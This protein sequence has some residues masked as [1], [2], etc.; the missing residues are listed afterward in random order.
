MFTN[1][2]GGVVRR[3]YDL[4]F[5][6]SYETRFR[7]AESLYLFVINIVLLGMN[8]IP[9]CASVFITYFRSAT[10]YRFEPRHV[11][12]RHKIKVIIITTAVVG[13]RD[14]HYR[15]LL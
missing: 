3:E 4:N 2:R 7:P 1:A 14:V 13:T 9:A 11:F 15:K 12:K 8:D 10:T 5:S 6:R